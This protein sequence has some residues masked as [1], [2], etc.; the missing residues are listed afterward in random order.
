MRDKLY[1][2]LLSRPEEGDPAGLLELIFP[3]SSSPSEFGKEFLRGLLSD[4]PRFL[5][6][7]A[8]GEWRLVDDH[9]FAVD[10]SEV[11][12]VVVDL[13]G[14]GNSPGRGGITE[15]GAVRLEDGRILDTFETFVNPERRIPSYV[16]KMTGITD[17]MVTGAPTISE[18]IGDFLAFAEGSVLVAHNASFDIIS[19]DIACQRHLGR[20]LGIPWLCTVEM[21][22]RAWPHLQKTSLD[23]LAEHFDLH[24]DTRHRALADAEL[25]AQILG[26]LF[27]E[28][29]ERGATTI[30]EVT[31]VLEGDEP[32]RSLEIHV[33][34]DALERIPESP[35]SYRLID[36]NGSTLLVSRAS[37]LREAV[38]PYFLGAA[39]LSDRQVGMVA[40]VHDVRFIATGSELEAAL[41]EANDVRRHEPT[42]NRGNRH[43]P[44][45][46]FLR[47]TVSDEF[48]AVYVS[49]RL[50]A[51]DA[52]YL[53]PLGNGALADEAA[54][55][56]SR[57][58][59]L[60]T[61]PGLLVPAPGF[62]ACSLGREGWC[63]SPCDQTVSSAEY[64]EQARQLQD[65]L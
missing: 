56:F 47:F 48:P 62:E 28:L 10:I 24:A 60:R 2:H 30:A 45:L 21:A 11:P 35:G 65:A 61:C 46:H 41:V 27:D 55:A 14:T 51:D 64:A 33:S 36:G 13:E 59:R 4:D 23:A 38:L 34:Q 58:F 44:R 1:K 49:P 17:E 43:L 54:R 37:N 8:T 5:E 7:S 12:F 20:P 42:F 53:G 9:L 6:D 18:V 63:S 26:R 31:S 39:H 3:G 16:A 29:R 40:G 19:L 52:L 25:T 50:R 57:R 32:R 22:R 15:I